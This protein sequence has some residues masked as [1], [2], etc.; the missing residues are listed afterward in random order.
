MDPVSNFKFKL[1]PHT[2]AL[3][4]FTQNK[5]TIIQVILIVMGSVSLAAGLLNIIKDGC[6]C[7]I[8]GANWLLQ[9]K[10]PYAA[11]WE[12]R[13]N[14]RLYRIPT[15]LPQEYYILIPFAL[16][17]DFWGF[18][19]YGIVGV[20]FIYLCKFI[21]R[22]NIHYVILFFL[23]LSTTTFRLNLG[24]GQFLCFYFGVFILFDYLITTKT[25]RFYSFFITPL[26]LV[27]LASKP[28]SFFWLPLY[29]P[30]KKKYL[31]IYL[32]AFV[33]QIII[34]LVFIFHTNISL[35]IFLKDY[36]KILSIHTSLASSV[37]SVFSINFSSY[38]Q[39]IS[40]VIVCIQIIFILM[41]SYLKY[42]K[43]NLID[44]FAWMFICICLSFIVVYH[45]NYD[46]FLLL[47]PLFVANKNPFQMKNAFFISLI[48]FMILEKIIFIS[49]KDDILALAIV[50]LFTLSIATLILSQFLAITIKE[51]SNTD[52]SKVRSSGWRKKT[53][54]K[55][56]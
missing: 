56:N 55:L 12:N 44:E 46:S 50:N 6:D 29:Y 39:S 36:I 16:L 4:Y 30:L 53:D 25:N 22:G 17:G 13:E 21:K 38:I 7:Q 2:K 51:S 11:F 8:E 45:G 24:S 48:I 1:M 47:L 54:N 9:N 49:I 31:I 52:L 19:L 32:V 40:S 3:A 28:T 5:Y 43:N 15:H 35:E 14:F 37:R 34:I 41:F 18:L 23:L 27:I 26:L 33:F 10:S 42:I 20:I